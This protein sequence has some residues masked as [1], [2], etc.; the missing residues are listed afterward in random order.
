MTDTT[1]PNRMNNIPSIPMTAAI[2]SNFISSAGNLDM[3][4]DQ[5]DDLFNEIDFDIDQMAPRAAAAPTETITPRQNPDNTIPPEGRSTLL[6][7]DMDD[8]FLNIDSTIEHVNAANQNPQAN[9]RDVSSASASAQLI[10]DAELLNISASEPVIDADNYR[11]KIRGLNLVTVKQLSECSAENRKRRKYFI[12]KATIEGIVDQARV[13]NKQWKLRVL[14]GDKLSQNE[15]MEASF[16]PDVVDKLVGVSGRELHQLY[17]TRNQRPQVAEEI[18]TILEGL[19]EK[20]DEMYMFMKI[21]FDDTS[22]I[23]VVVELINAAP[24]L[25]RKLQEKI[26]CE[27]LG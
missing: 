27:R 23:P 26:E 24:V 25:D 10:N 13:S 21:Q 18:A 4:D 1:Q 7:D 15:T 14:L 20:L 19:T 16:N 22:N 6:F 11:F 2:Q 9:Q 17:T 12:V 5:D 3:L 8:D